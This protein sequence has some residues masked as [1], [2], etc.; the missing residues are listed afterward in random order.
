[1][2]F[3]QWTASTY[4]YIFYSR[5]SPTV[6]LCPGGREDPLRPLRAGPGRERQG[7][8]QRRSTQTHR[9]NRHR[10]TGTLST[11][12]KV[13]DIN[14]YVSKSVGYNCGFDMRFNSFSFGR[15]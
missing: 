1:M 14:V 4:I 7:T 5:L 10:S 12:D 6:L 9:R 15:S 2:R 13:T 3:G 8:G 11:T